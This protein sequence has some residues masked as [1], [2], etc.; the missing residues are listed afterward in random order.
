MLVR[1]RQPFR[2]N[3]L[4]PNAEP[5]LLSDT[6][7]NFAKCSIGWGLIVCRKFVVKGTKSDMG[8]TFCKIFFDIESTR[9]QRKFHLQLLKKNNV[10]AAP[11]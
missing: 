5:Q 10:H 8:R 9:V 1:Q 3:K 4:E 6:G 2:R 7:M 11:R